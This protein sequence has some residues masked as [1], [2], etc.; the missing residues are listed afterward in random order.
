MNKNINGEVLE[1]EKDKLFLLQNIVKLDGRLI[2][3][4]PNLKGF[5]PLNCY[6]LKEDTVFYPK[7]VHWN[8]MPAVE[9]ITGSRTGQHTITGP[10]TG[11]RTNSWVMQLQ[12]DSYKLLASFYA[13]SFNQYI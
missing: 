8:S 6:V 3:F 1:L 4:P 9:G 13:L 12:L 10:C 11:Q 5:A 2:A 7:C